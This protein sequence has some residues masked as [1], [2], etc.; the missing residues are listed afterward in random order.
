MFSRENPSIQFNR[1]LPYYYLGTICGFVKEGCRGMEGGAFNSTYFYQ[2]SSTEDQAGR[3]L[4][5]SAPR[6]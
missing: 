3:Y 4:P 6:C 1:I 2:T 5:S